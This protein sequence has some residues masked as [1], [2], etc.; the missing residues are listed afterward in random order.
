MRRFTLVV[1]IALLIPFANFHAQELPPNREFPQEPSLT[2]PVLGGALGGLGGWLAGGIV[3]AAADRDCYELECVEGFLIGAAA[4][5]TLG[6]ALGTHLGNR[7]RGSFAL[8]VL[9]GAAV[10][11]ASLG[12][13]YLVGH[14]LDEAASV[15]VWIAEPILQFITTVAVE[16]ATGRAR[17]RS[18]GPRV[19]V[20]PQ[21]DGVG[22]GLTFAF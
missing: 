3:G 4:G 20:I 2:W 16:R 18:R 15:A 6:L 17:A 9:S 12:A 19:S 7:R 14:D 10:W 1:V 22:L 8:D 11:G 5:G 13:F 21:R